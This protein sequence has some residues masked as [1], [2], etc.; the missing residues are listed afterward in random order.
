MTMFGG[1]IDVRW[2]QLRCTYDVTFRAN[3][4]VQTRPLIRHELPTGIV[5]KSNVSDNLRH[6]MD[7]LPVTDAVNSLTGY[8]PR[9]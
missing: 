1:S 5:L 2:L 9:E 4:R 7:C 8:K 3:H 6:V